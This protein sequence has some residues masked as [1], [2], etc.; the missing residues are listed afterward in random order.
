MPQLLFAPTPHDDAI[1]FINGKPA[2]AR[3]V[4]DQLLPE[5]KPLAFTIAGIQS[6]DALQQIRDMVATLPAGQSW[7]VVKKQIAAAISPYVVDPAASAEDQAKQQYRALAKAELLLRLHG[8]QCYAA[9]SEAVLQRQKKA[10]PFSMYVTMGDG[11]VRPS[12]RALDGV[13]LPVDDP[14]WNDHTP[15][16][17]WGCRCLKIAMSKGDVADVK[18]QDAGKLPD[19]QRVLDD[20]Q[21]QRLRTDF[22]ITRNGQDVDVRTD[23]DLG[24]ENPYTFNP[25][26]LRPDVAQLKARY[27]ATTWAE[28]ERFARATEY[29]PGKTVWDWLTSL[30]P[31]P[32]PVP[33]PAPKPVAAP[34]PP[35]P[36]APVLPAVPFKDEIWWRT[37]QPEPGVL[38]GVEFAPVPK[39]WWDKVKDV[40]VGEPRPLS[41]IKR[42]GVLIREP[43][44]RVWIVQ[45]TNQFGNRKNTWP[46]GGVEKGLTVQQNALKEV[47]EET[48]L[49]VKITGYLGD[50]RDS[51]NS[52]NGRLYIGERIGGAPWDAKIESF[53]KDAKTGKPAAESEAVG[54]VTLDRAA[55]L[56]HRT[57]DLAQLITVRPIP[58]DTPVRGRGSEALKKFVEAVLPAA[59]EY[60]RQQNAASNNPGNAEL[61]A[62]QNLRGY[63]G[64]P[65]A[66]SKADFDKL[67][68]KGDHTEMLRGVKSVGGSTAA[69]F[70]ADF[71]QGNHFPGYGI[72]GS[73]T[74]ADSNGRRTG[75]NEASNY[76]GSS[77]VVM[78]MALPKTAKIINVDEL[79]RMVPGNPDL[80]KGYARRGGKAAAECWMGVQAVLAGYDAIY[81]NGR[82]RR[83]GTYGR[84]F[85]VILNRGIMTVQETAVPRT[86]TIP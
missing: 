25:R 9:T 62:V 15:P 83:Y 79:E 58:L 84:G 12:H 3:D 24:K 59:R 78:R 49:Q 50:F 61:N 85:Y 63:N 13:V 54:L 46:G 36:A 7:D 45:P 28:F 68:A 64:V 57:D 19:Q 60:E 6:A 21:R 30:T 66:L 37:G 35:V 67:M 74:Y 53:I 69:S 23:V 55:K 26:N 2:M 70:F 44:G 56:L 22:K 17:A 76:A 82:S 80:F 14:F 43:D 71:K 34:P 11:R 39:G 33:V 29:A 65:T 18:T 86:Y 72:F 48:G 10:F 32:P 81:V 41:P 47:W 73:G 16:W 1:A 40:D 42:A 5:L 27:D 4:F 20:A 51:N 52:N 77:G 38:N 75:R 8:G 31:P